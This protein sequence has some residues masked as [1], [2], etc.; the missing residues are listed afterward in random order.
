MHS[1]RSAAVQYINYGTGGAFELPTQSGTYIY[2]LRIMK[3]FAFPAKNFTL[4]QPQFPF[5]IHWLG[6]AK[7]RN[8]LRPTPN[9]PEGFYEIYKKNRFTLC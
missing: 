1:L 2:I 8:V 3:N 5:T 9:P 6:T 4:T 7:P